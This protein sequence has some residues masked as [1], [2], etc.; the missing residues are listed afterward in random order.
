MRLELKRTWAGTQRFEERFGITAP[1]AYAYL[2]AIAFDN[3]WGPTISANAKAPS[4]EEFQSF[5]RYILN[6]KSKLTAINL[7]LLDSVKM[8][9]NKFMFHISKELYNES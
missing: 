9:F 4:I 3:K 5:Q 2:E 6:S 8:N 1:V 7:E